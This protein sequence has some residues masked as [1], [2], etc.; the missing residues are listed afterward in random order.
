MKILIFSNT[1]GNFK[2]S[3]SQNGYNGG[4]WMGTLQTELSKVSD[5]Q[6]GVCFVAEGFPAKVEQDGVTYY[7]V[8]SARKRLKDKLLDAL[9]P[10]DVHRDEVLWPHYKE[11]FKKAIDDFR[12]DIIHIFGSELYLGLAAQV[13]TCPCV[14][15]IQG[16][17]SLSIY[18]YLPPGISRHD[19]IRKDGWRGV[20]ANWSYLN[21][22]ERSVYREKAALKAVGHVIGRTGWDREAAAILAPQ[23]KYHFGGEILRPVFYE[24]ARRALPKRLTLMTTSSAPLY[25]GFDI[26]LRVASILKN[27]CRVDFE[28]NVFGNVAP[29]LAEK[30]TH[31]SHKDLGIFLRGVATAEELRAQLLQ[32]TLYFQPSYIENSPNSVCEAQLLGL[33]IVATNVGGTSSIVADGESGLL[34]PATDPYMGASKVLRLYHDAAL[35]EKMGEVGKSAAFKRHDRKA[36]VGQLIETYRQM[37]DDKLTD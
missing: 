25:K 7:P 11:R 32:S 16:L 24:P 21:Y 28:W 31:L 1:A 20:W 35:N 5:I 37:L 27:E 13:T 18:I 22:W 8:P 19:Y 3:A 14:L 2:T 12:P 6:L 17:P 34:F 36:I 30:E 9:N 33:P 10:H 29:R 4:G 26:I 15:H 23:A